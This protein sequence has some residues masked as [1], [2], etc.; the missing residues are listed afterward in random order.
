[1]FVMLIISFFGGL[2]AGVTVC[3]AND[4]GAGD[5]KGF[6]DTAHTAVL[7]SAL[8]G[9]FIMLLGEIIAKPVLMAM[10]VPEDIRPGA[11]LYLR[12]YMP[13]VRY[14]SLQ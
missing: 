12:L 8:V 7:L 14:L 11:V 10:D 13:L 5:R 6:D 3:A 1:V 4:W 2:S 9:L